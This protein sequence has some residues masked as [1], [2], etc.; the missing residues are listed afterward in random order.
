MPVAPVSHTPLCVAHDATFWPWH[1]WPEFA[2]WP[3]PASTLV[4]VPIAGFGEWGLGHGQDVEETVLNHVLRRALELD[5]PAPH[6]LLVIPP[7][8]FVFAPNDDSPFALDPP[9]FH[10]LLEEVVTSIKASGFRRILLYNASPWNDPLTAAAARDL[11]IDHELQMFRICLSGLDLGFD[12]ATNPH[13]RDLQTL[14]TGLTGAAPRGPA[15]EGALPLAA[16]TDAATALLDRA[17]TRLAGLLGEIQAWPALP[18]EGRIPRA[19]PPAA[20]TSTPTTPSA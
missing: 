13:H 11:R 10:T 2:H 1:R 7:L 20:S 16:A 14:L 19:V 8:R 15:A 6:S 17:A 3:D 9:T 5:T 12:A 4:V 18:D